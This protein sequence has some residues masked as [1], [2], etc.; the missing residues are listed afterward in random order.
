MAWTSYA[1]SMSSTL[2]LSDIPGVPDHI[3]LWGLLIPIQ[4]ALQR[5]A[6]C[7]WCVCSPASI[8]LSK[9]FRPDKSICALSAKIS[10]TPSRKSGQER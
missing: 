5:T 9:T 10:P 3:S 4:G 8:H 2:A 1:V 6:T 7:G